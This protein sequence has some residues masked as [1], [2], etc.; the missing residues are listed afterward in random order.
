MLL[1]AKR[2]AIALICFRVEEGR[3]GIGLTVMTGVG[4]ELCCEIGVGSGF[5][6][7]DT[8]RTARLDI[9]LSTRKHDD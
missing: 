4:T 1:E 8:A 2:E 3:A 6:D 9:G 7:D 5:D